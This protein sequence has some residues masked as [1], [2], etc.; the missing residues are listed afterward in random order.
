[1]TSP[2]FAI[3]ARSSRPMGQR[4]IDGGALAASLRDLLL[5]SALLGAENGM[6]EVVERIRPAL[7]GLGVPSER[8]SVALAIVALRRG[9]GQACLRIVE[10]ELLDRGA[11]HELAL[12]IQA[13][14]WRLLGRAE[15]RSQAAALLV[16]SVD[17][18]VRSIA[19]AGLHAAA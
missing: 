3:L 16:T 8:L 14:A 18:L 6:A 10:A 15:G 17:P 19:R 5:H 9:D 2:A 11:G 13:V 12:A 1:M 7:L 4:Q